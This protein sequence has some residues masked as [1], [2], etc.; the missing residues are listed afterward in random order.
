MDRWQDRYD[1]VKV[2]SDKADTKVYLA[3][4]KK[5]KS[6]RI[7]KLFLKTSA[8]YRF[9]SKEVHLLK[10]LAHS[11]I[12]R[13]YDVEEDDM[14]MWLVEEYIEG[15]TLY[16]KRVRASLAKDVIL[17]Y[18]LRICDIIKYLHSHDPP[19]LYLD[20]KPQNVIISNDDAYLVDF[21]SA[22]YAKDSNKSL[23]F[24]TYGYASPEQGNRQGGIDERADVYGIGMLVYHML[25]GEIPTTRNGNK[26]IINSLEG[27]DKDLGGLVANCIRQEPWFRYSKVDEVGRR[28]MKIS[29]KVSK[30]RRTGRKG[31]S[32]YER[33]KDKGIGNKGVKDKGTQNPSIAIAG[34]Q[35]RIGT[36]HMS[37][38]LS[39][40]LSKSLSQV[41]Y[42][43]QNQSGFIRELF[44]YSGISLKAG[45]NKYRDYDM[46]I[47]LADS[48]ILSVRKEEVSSYCKIIDFGMLDKDNVDEF[49]S[50]DYKILVLG[51]KA[52]E[53]AHSKNALS[54]CLSDDG[55]CYVFNFLE[56]SRFENLSKELLRRRCHRMPYEPDVLG[57]RNNQRIGEFL[58]DVLEFL[59]I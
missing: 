40:Y 47:S 26:D 57:I 56:A 15:E 14:C 53:L 29:D 58:S 12:P 39:E 52:W 10:A 3:L 13:V 43:E 25:T 41:I 51:G 35:H 45:V 11:G 24:G 22:I 50:S 55:I 2:L 38:M 31:Y 6:H 4:H 36:T 46:G 21:G 16:E 34:S 23:I 54:L 28:L 20:L 42:L 44:I 17:R 5:L 33:H 59:G 8:Y 9:F 30:G 32:V 18:A 49:L 48:N 19:V 27:Q 37:L 1:V 7:I